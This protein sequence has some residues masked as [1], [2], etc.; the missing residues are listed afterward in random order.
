MS[1]SIQQFLLSTLLAAAVLGIVLPAPAAD[2]PPAPDPAKAKRM[3]FGGK[4]KA[5]DKVAKTITIDREN[6]NTFAVT[7]NTKITKAGKPATL[8]DAVIGED[9]GG[10]AVD[11]DGKLELLSL[12]LG[13][14]PALPPAAPTPAK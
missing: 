11:K 5:I 6:K 12:R 9:V 14:K 10:L 7:S 3:P 4:L 13:A 1:K 8:N 2:T